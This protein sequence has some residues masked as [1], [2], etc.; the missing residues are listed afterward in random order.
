MIARPGTGRRSPDF[1]RSFPVLLLSCLLH[2]NPL[3]AYSLKNCTVSYSGRVADAWVSCKGHDLTAVPD[4]IP[5][6]AVRLDLSSN[7][8][9]KISGTDFRYL[10]KLRVVELNFNLISRIDDGAFADLAEL[11]VLLMWENKLTNL[12]DKMFQGLS[13]LVV[14]SLDRNHIEYIAPLAFQSLL[15]LRTVSLGSNQLQ[16]MADIMPL[17]RLPSLHDL[18]LG[19]NH[20]TS[21]QSNDLPFNF[22][23]ELRVLALRLNPLNKFSIT[24]DIFPHLQSMDLSKCSRNFEWDVPDKSFLRSLTY[25]YLRGSEIS[26]DA[27]I[28][29][30]RTAD[31][32][33]YLLLN[34]M[35]EWIE[36]GLVDIAC[37][38]PA[39]RNL[40][41]SSNKIGRV[42][43]ELL[44]SCSQLTELDLSVNDLT[45]LS[46]DS[47]RSVKQLRR[48]SLDRNGLSKVPLALRGVSTLEILDLSLNFISE[49]G[50]S[51]FLNLIGLTELNLN[52]NRISELK[53]CVFQNLNGLKVLNIG[54]NN[55]FTLGNTFQLGLPK[56]E[57]LNL[58]R[59]GFRT[60]RKGD[61]RNL[62]SL[63]SLDLESDT[64]LNVEKGAF[65]GLDDLRTLSLSIDTYSL[66]RPG[67]FTGLRHLENLT[68]H[69]TFAWSIRSSH[70]NNTPP[71]TYLS[72]LKMLIMKVF[73]DHHSH[74]SPDLLKGLKSLEHFAAENFFIS[75]P[76][77]DTFKHTPQLKSLLISRSDL[78]DLSPELFQPIPNLQA[79]DLSNS[80]LRSLDF[81]ARANLSG[82]T[83]L[84]ASQN[85]LT[86]INETVV[87]SLPA[88]TYL[89]LL[90]NPFSCDCSSSGFNQWVQSNNQ[91]QVVN[92][93]QYTCTYPL[94]ER[95]TKFL[96]FD[97]HSCWM[98]ANFLC[99]ICSTCVIVLTLLTSF[100][101]HL[102]RWQLAYAYYLFLAFLYDSRRRK[103]GAPLRYDAFVSY[104][105]QDEAWV[106]R[107]MLPVLE[108]EQGWRLCLHHR[109]FQPG[110][111]IIENITEAI[112][113]SRKTICVISRRYLE[114][115]WCS[116]EIQMASFRLFDE[117]KDVLILV[118][119]EELPARRLPPCYRMRKLLKRRTYLSWP[120]AGRHP[121]VFWQNVG[122]ALETGDGP[123]ESAHTHLLSGPCCSV[124]AMFLRYSVY[125]LIAGLYLSSSAP[126]PEDC[127]R[128]VTPLPLENLTKIHGR[129]NFI[130]G[131]T[132]HEIFDSILKTLDSHWCRITP[133]PSSNNTLTLFEEN[134]M[135][136]KCHNS[137]HNM[138]VIG[139][140][141]VFTHYNNKSTAH[142]LQACADCLVLSYNSTVGDMD[143]S[144]RSHNIL[145][146]SSA[147]EESDLET[148]RQQAECLGFSQPPNFHYDPKKDFCPDDEAQ[149]M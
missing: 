1:L 44:Q 124:S 53:G 73:D 41:L 127:Q 22:S 3:L 11:R 129:W 147:L 47:L 108:G 137:V 125:F 126:T 96:D 131:F 98:D 49:L 80:K 38:I 70:V 57:V 90:G 29:V 39:L 7:R 99:Y 26:F 37:Q 133:S 40:D 68:L 52:H 10:S 115:E 95:G 60:I 82:L 109:D 97:S 30:L 63:R 88:L 83:W 145:G 65:E 66:D 119:L 121:G 77:P 59:N 105:V 139:D 15:S 64:Y 89:D 149:K 94:S 13:S 114:S 148:F 6:D 24:R 144:I 92:G 100:I 123:A 79:L 107:E 62:S 18:D 46:E 55:V 91:T 69:L 117:Q 72:S 36:D 76:D 116:R 110:K 146:R 43:D 19:Y 23:S 74:I 101:Y 140:T 8:L 35:E 61:F 78:S 112:Y 130:E 12:T 120:R 142:M 106:H 113:G 128:L 134:M 84:K 14:L 136:G 93:H 20:F 42:D 4:D 50:C 9:L 85:D 54:E 45:E 32:V 86:V 122:R 132:D 138:T 34:Y 103:T 141:M 71:F 143:V 104:N 28:E 2:L 27:Y 135:N 67:F 33:E 5:R 51:D 87:H 25:L 102:L 56:L 16:Q 58:H 21:F 31:S 75:S 118:F 111:P 48:L 17:L 81:L